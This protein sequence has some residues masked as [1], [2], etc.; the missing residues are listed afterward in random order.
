ME[1]SDLFDKWS[2]A[3]FSIWFLIGKSK[4][5]TPFTFLIANVVWE[6]WENTDTGIQWW[7]DRGQTEYTGDSLLNS[8]TDIMW[9]YIGFYL[10]NVWR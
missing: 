7:N 6:I 1:R 9:G 5:F 3:H 8:I 4:M 2:V 10:G